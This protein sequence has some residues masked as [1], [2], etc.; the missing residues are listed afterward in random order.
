MYLLIRD[1]IPGPGVNGHPDCAE[2][3]E[4]L[5]RG[6]SDPVVQHRDLGVLGELADGDVGGRGQARQRLGQAGGRGGGRGGA[7]ASE[8]GD[9]E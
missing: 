5:L 4:L 9:L 8:G 6:D 1:S 2:L 3:P 7:P